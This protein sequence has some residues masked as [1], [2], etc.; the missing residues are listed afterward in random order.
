MEYKNFF[1]DTDGARRKV[2][3]FA[4]QVLAARSQPRGPTHTL[5]NLAIRQRFVKGIITTNI[6]GL[7][8]M[9]NS[10]LT[11]NVPVYEALFSVA[12]HSW[13]EPNDARVAY[14]HGD[15][16][17]VAC[18]SCWQRFPLTSTI[19][20]QLMEGAMDP[21]ELCSG[22]RSPPLSFWRPDIIFYG[23]TREELKA[24]H[25]DDTYSAKP[26]KKRKRK[27]TIGGEGVPGDSQPTTNVEK[28]QSMITPGDGSG[29]PDYLFVIGS[30]LLN[31]NLARDLISLSNG[32]TEMIFVNPQLPAIVKHMEGR[33]I[34]VNSTAD[35]FSEQL[36]HTMTKR[37]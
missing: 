11:P 4:L 34:W 29:V 2:W 12:G 32:G 35:T 22:K 27:I 24:E 3:T 8:T 31:R 5:A 20:K 9:D 1:N 10:L 37:T 25:H 14:L 17:T 15:I 7:E 21:C 19:A 28:Y 36:L 13:I 26:S 30:S 18:S 6:D 16:C 23:D 33:V